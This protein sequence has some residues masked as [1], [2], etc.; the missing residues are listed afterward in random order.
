MKTAN[1]INSAQWLAGSSLPR[2]I[3]TDHSGTFAERYKIYKQILIKCPSGA[4]F[5]KEL[6]HLHL[7][8]KN[9]N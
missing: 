2:S 1:K 7:N 6:L 3:A 5:S 9:N 8:R 4:S